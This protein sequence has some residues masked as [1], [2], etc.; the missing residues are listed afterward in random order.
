VHRG[1]AYLAR[2][3]RAD[4]AWLPLWFGNQYAPEDA[5]PT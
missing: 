1:L 2:Q 4:G 3:Q 5:N